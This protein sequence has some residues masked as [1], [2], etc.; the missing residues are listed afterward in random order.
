MME[1]YSDVCGNVQL[2]RRSSDSFTSKSLVKKYCFN[3][4]VKPFIMDIFTIVYSVI[5]NLSISLIRDA[6]L[7]Y[8]SD[9]GT[10]QYISDQGTHQY[11]SDQ[12]THQYI[13]DQ[14]THQYISDQGTHQYISDQGTHQYISDQGT[15]QYISDQGTHQYISDQGTHLYNITCIWHWLKCEMGL[16][17]QKCLNPARA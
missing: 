8:I 4:A 12:G 17:Q 3:D 14:G 9:Q 16:S 15:H 2:Y 11:I 5:R 1:I 10:H 7:Q 6:S 13:S